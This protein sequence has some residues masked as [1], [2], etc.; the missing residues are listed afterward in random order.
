MTEAQT[1]RRGQAVAK[2]RAKKNGSPVALAISASP[3]KNQTEYARALGIS[4]PGLSRYISGSLPCP[5]NIADRV[6]ADFGLGD[7]VWPGGVVD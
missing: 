3:W 7:D 6:K 2:A 4:Q 5:R 1:T